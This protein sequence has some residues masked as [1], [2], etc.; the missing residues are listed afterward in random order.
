MAYS[1][2]EVFEK[3][4]YSPL[5][6]RS[7]AP[8]TQEWFYGEWQEGFGRKV[9]RFRILK[10]G[11]PVGFFQAVKYP[12]LRNKYYIYVPHGPVIESE[13]NG[14][15]WNELKRCLL[16]LAKK[17]NAVFVRIDPYP[18]QKIGAPWKGAPLSSYFGAYFQSKYDWILN[19][20]RDEKTILSG[21]HPKTRYSINLS[22]RGKLQFEMESG[23]KMMD[24]FEKFYSLMQ[25]TAERGKFALHPK[26]YY[27]LIFRS[28]KNDNLISLFMAKHEG[29]ALAMHLVIYYGQ[30]AYYPFGAST[31]KNSELCPTYG[32]HWNALL[33][34]K[35]RGC[36]MYNF[37]AIEASEALSHGNWQGISAFKRKFGGS[38][39]EYSD[40]Y[41]IVEDKLWYLLYII[42][43][44][45]KRI[46]A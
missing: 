32:L 42:R 13:I 27:E 31:R 34:G 40:F 30:V 5:D 2:E 33:E 26:K 28:A 39:L 43:K 36:S 15:F 22:L 12:L 44:Q 25:E 11:Q 18:K 8:F 24:H 17:E 29:E 10:E 19:I 35:R 6:V 20:S 45:A 38:L 3:R 23:E 9:F 4:E 41:D 16:E 37:G 14:D 46:S 1:I 21:M 7:D